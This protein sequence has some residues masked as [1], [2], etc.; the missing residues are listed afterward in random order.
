MQLNEIITA[1]M[2]RRQLLGLCPKEVAARASVGE[3][4]IYKWEFG[5]SAPTLKTLLKVLDALDLEIKIVERN[6]Q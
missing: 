2:E 4:Q 5:S 6:E 1:A 3:N